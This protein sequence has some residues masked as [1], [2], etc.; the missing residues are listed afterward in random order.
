MEV[1]LIDELDQAN[2]LT[3]E[4]G[5]FLD[6]KA[7]DIEPRKLA[8]SLSAFANTLGGEIYVGI[9]QGDRDNRDNTWI[10]GLASVEDANDHLAIF[11][12]CGGNSL[13]RAEF[14]DCGDAGLVLRF[15]IR[16]TQFIVRAP[17][18]K[19]YFRSGAQ[20]LPADAEKERRIALDK[21]TTTHE[22][23]TLDI[24]IERVTNSVTVL[25]FM[26]SQVPH[27]EPEAWMK[28][29]DLIRE[30]LPRVAA[31]LLFDDNPQ[32]V[33]AK[34]SAV[35]IVRYS[36]VEGE[37]SRDTMVGTPITVEGCAYDLIYSA[38]AQTKAEV[39]G[40]K[41]YT[42]AGMEEISYPEETLH[43]VI[44]NAI[45]HRDYSKPQDVQIRIY[46]DRIEVWSPG[47]LP[48]HVTVENC[49]EEQAA[50]NGKLVRLINKFPNPPNKDLG[51]GLNTAYEAMEKLRLKPPEL[52]ERDG[53]VVVAIRHERLA[54]PEQ[55]ILEYVDENGTITNQIGRDITGLRRDVQVKDVFVRLRNSGDLEMVPG[56]RG[57][58]SAWR[59]P[60]GE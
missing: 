27:G 29:Q 8:K 44:A 23:T 15:Q 57:R 45:L 1:I 21:G 36:G 40:I 43:E 48:G 32:A 13:G 58:A 46:D 50:R 59:R 14:L 6:L 9:S 3:K 30:G 52:I 34:R 51:E 5:H 53:F 24:D 31:V 16:K 60:T 33:L 42:E 49:L 35:K 2:L 7:K 11:E 19:C 18:G 54:S 12:G 10:A 25:E 38:V 47:T 41:K 4:E 17:D 28:S 26:L 39:E 37:I 22:D 55:I 56:K 20:S